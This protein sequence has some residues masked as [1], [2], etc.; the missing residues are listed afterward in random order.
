MGSAY[1]KRHVRRAE[2]GKEGETRF[3]DS[4]SDDNA[5]REGRAQS[6]FLLRGGGAMSD[7]DDDREDA[8]EL[9][10]KALETMRCG[11]AFPESM[12][13]S[14]TETLY[15]HF[16]C[17]NVEEMCKL[18]REV[19]GPVIEV[20]HP[21]AHPITKLACLRWA[22]AAAGMIAEVQIPEKRST[23]RTTHLKEVSV[24]PIS[25]KICHPAEDEEP[26]DDA[27]EAGLLLSGS[28]SKREKMI[29]RDA[30]IT[31]MTM[32]QTQ[33][34][35]ASLHAGFV[36]GSEVV[37]GL[38]YGTDIALTEWSR[39][40]VK[41]EHVTLP[42]LIAKGEWSEINEFLIN[43]MR[44]Y[45][46]EGMSTETT[47]IT[48]TLTSI[49]ELFE[50]DPKGKLM[51]LKALRTKYK[52]RGFPLV[53]GFDTGL[54]VKSMKM[55]GGSSGVSALATKVS[56]LTTQLATLTSQMASLKTEVAAIK[57]RAPREPRAGEDAAADKAC[58]Y[59]KQV[60]HF[61]RQCPTKKADEAAK[62]KE[63]KEAKAAESKEE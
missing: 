29:K 60:G 22:D 3:S 59:C 24:L 62:A 20:V 63:E 44:L 61:A 15:D 5:S 46:D 6:L 7:V 34:F 18:G 51:Y 1:A 2:L 32:K 14:I 58:G 25:R 11:A 13:P 31:G 16:G 39:K 28:G 53:D 50:G 36:C 10:R 42:K 21:E 52:G 49:N 38:S 30:T 9:M 17:T 57:N 35:D 27:S 12:T 37:E 23:T 4:G 43:L 8:L 26:D 41:H 45:N 47:Q 33:T 54:I 56:A 19:F 48:S 55:S 40:L